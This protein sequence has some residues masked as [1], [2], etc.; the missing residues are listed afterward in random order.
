MSEARQDQDRSAELDALWREGL[1]RLVGQAEP[2]PGV[3]Q[4]VARRVAGGPTATPRQRAERRSPGQWATLAA[5]LLVC[6]TWPHGIACRWD[7]SQL[8][9]TWGEG[10]A[11]PAAPASPSVA[12]GPLAIDAQD[13]ASGYLH[14]K[15][16]RAA[17]ALQELNQPNQDP[18][19]R[20]RKPAPAA[21]ASAAAAR[22]PEAAVGHLPQDP[23]SSPL[24]LPLP[25]D[26][27][28]AAPHRG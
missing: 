7:G 18:L 16:Q 8:A 3:W 9:C 12:A 28:S 26:E 13:A 27:G 25:R 21:V 2:P 15:Q 17:R 14:H 23:P 10:G 4:R 24:H 1:H 11:A 6:L 22:P 19:L 20:T 5:I